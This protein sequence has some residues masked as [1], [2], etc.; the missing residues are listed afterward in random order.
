MARTFYREW[1]VERGEETIEV[2]IDF[3]MT[4]IIPAYTSGLPEDCYPEEGGEIEL[5]HC[6]R[7]S[8]ENMKNAPEFELTDDEWD[9]FCE[10][11]WMDPPEDEPD[12]GDF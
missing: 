2:C 12:Y 3:T 9:A 11:V 1:E 7:K 4:P 5:E 8:D 10:R 6:W